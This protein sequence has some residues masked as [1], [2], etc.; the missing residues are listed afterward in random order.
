M[1]RH[2]AVET[3]FGAQ[4][5]DL[6]CGRGSPGGSVTIPGESGSI[7]RQQCTRETQPDEPQRE[8][9]EFSWGDSFQPWQ[10]DS[11]SVGGPS[12][13]IH[14]YLARRVES[15]AANSGASLR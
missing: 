4:D 1:T 3:V 13:T 9:V 15:R 8:E 6:R 2:R 5:G 14:L 10:D 12:L 7:L 11:L